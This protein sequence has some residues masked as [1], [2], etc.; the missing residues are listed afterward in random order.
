MP[1]SLNGEETDASAFLRETQLLSHCRP[2]SSAQRE[3]LIGLGT[4][5]LYKNN[6]HF[7]YGGL[8]LKVQQLLDRRTANPAPDPSPQPRILLPLSLASRQAVPHSCPPHPTR[9]P[10]F[11]PRSCCVSQ[12]ASL[13]TF[14][15]RILR[16]MKRR[17]IHTSC[18][19]DRAGR[20]T[21]VSYRVIFG[22]PQH[23]EQNTAVSANPTPNV[24]AFTL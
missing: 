3:A 17:N 21:I 2:Q 14:T 23:M 24:W 10:R 6:V 1:R 15:D 18:A 4:S 8:L 5:E 12:V 9:T 19:R 20:S 7:K 16:N 22:S 13:S 11:V